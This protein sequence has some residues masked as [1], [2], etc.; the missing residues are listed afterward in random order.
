M[1]GLTRRGFI[2]TSAGAAVGVATAGVAGGAISAA[3][4]SSAGNLVAAANTEKTLVAYVRP[5]SSGEVTVVT[6]NREVTYH[7]AALVRRI[8]KAAE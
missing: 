2:T 3:L 7:D 8:Q 5:G 6:G 1:A 4:G